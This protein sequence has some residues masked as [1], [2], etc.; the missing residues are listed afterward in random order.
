[1]ATIEENRRAWND[2]HD[3][4]QAGEEWSSSWGSVRMQWYATLL[5]R[6]QAYLPAKTILEIAPGFGRWTQ[7]LHPLCHRLVVVDLSE[8]CITACR[9]RFS[10]LDHIEYHVNDGT[11]LEAVEDRSIDF[12]YSF[13][14]LVHAEEDVMASYLQELSKKLQPNGIG[15]VHHSNLGAHQTYL[16]ALSMCPV[17]IKRGLTRLGMGELVNTHWRGASMTAEKFDALAS[18]VGIRCIS[19]EL[20]SWWSYP[21]TDCISVFTLG[22]PAAKKVTKNPNFMREAR[23][24]QRLNLIYGDGDQ[25]PS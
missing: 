19:Q 17:R 23:N 11:S 9:K 18:K 10:D 1:M 22:A 14:S 2:V 6:V 4:A 7:F 8:R 13:D 25:P 21:L 20:F 12:V 16:K 15:F 5:P 24:A 3:W